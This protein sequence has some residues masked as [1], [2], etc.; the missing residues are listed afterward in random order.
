MRFSVRLS[1]L[2]AVLATMAV[3]ASSASAATQWVNDD[4]AVGANTSCASPGYNTINA[5]ITAATSGA[6]TVMVCDG[7]YAES[8]VLN[9][10]LIV[11]GAQAGVDARA[12]AAS[13]SIISPAVG[14]GL[15]TFPGATGSTI[16]GFTFSGPGRQLESHSG[17]LNNL[18]ILN[19]RFLVTAGGNGTFLND[20]G[21]DVTLSQNSYAGGGTSST[22][23][24]FDTD[25][26]NGLHF[27]RNWLK[28]SSGTGLFVDGN[29]NVGPSV[30]RTPLIDGNTFDGNGTGANLGTRAFGSFTVA[31]AGTISNNTFSNSAFDGLQGGIQHTTIEDNVFSGNGRNGLALSNLGSAGADRGGQFTMVLDNQFTGNGFTQAGAGLFFSA[32]QT[33]GTI[34]TNEAHNNNLDG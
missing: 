13:E 5:A 17:S 22:L 34:S 4:A 25:A 15:G 6:D 29:H 23:A 10:N 31:N 8:V 18:R 28:N 27:T 11:N 14:N 12:R 33:A 1:C 24:H 16:D 26:F 21:T 3:A 7:T 32:G 30:A 19:N 20:P 9:K 2:T